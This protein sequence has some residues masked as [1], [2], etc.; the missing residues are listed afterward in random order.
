MFY[1]YVKFLF[2]KREESKHHTKRSLGS[3]FSR[4]GYDTHDLSLQICSNTTLWSLHTN[5]ET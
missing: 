4:R 3:L 2:P 5:V 1:K